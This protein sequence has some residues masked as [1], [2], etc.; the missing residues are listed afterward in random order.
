M[1]GNIS[2]QQENAYIARYLSELPEIQKGDEYV[3]KRGESLWNIA[4]KELAQKGKAP[5]NSEI[6]EYILKIAKLNNLLTQEKMNNI[7]VGENIFL[8][9]SDINK[10]PVT[11]FEIATSYQENPI[12]GQFAKA[13]DPVTSPTQVAQAPIHVVESKPEEAVVSDAIPEFFKFDFA[14]Y[15]DSPVGVKVVKVD[16]EQPQKAEQAKTEI[17][18]AKI[19][20]PEIM[21][22]PA[23]AAEQSSTRYV[24][25]LMKK[26]TFSKSDDEFIAYLNNKKESGNTFMEYEASSLNKKYDKKIDKAEN[27][28]AILKQYKLTDEISE[29]IKKNENDVV[30]NKDYKKINTEKTQE[31]AELAFDLLTSLIEGKEAGYTYNL[32]SDKKA[33]SISK[34]GNF[35]SISKDGDI[36]QWQKAGVSKYDMENLGKLT[37]KQ[38]LDA[39]RKMLDFK[40]A[41]KKNKDTRLAKLLMGEESLEV[42]P[43]KE[44]VAQIAQ[45]KPKNSSEQKV[46]SLLDLASDTSLTIVE[47]DFNADYLG[48]YHLK[49][50]D[51]PVASINY[52]ENKKDITKITAY[53]IVNSRSASFN[54]NRNGEVELCR[55]ISDRERDGQ[56]SK[57]ETEKL[58]DWARNLMSNTVAIA[59]K[60]QVE[61]QPKSQ[62]L[63]TQYVNLQTSRKMLE[64]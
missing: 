18:I 12:K 24:A 41:E 55:S 29:V 25:P 22:S 19:E 3:I 5:K 26:E 14:S 30:R 32:S 36:Q 39:L 42:T 46:M 62:P 28:I 49:K 23:Y 60:K 40:A 51:S 16:A 64:N 10:E 15:K 47:A 56:L 35:Y 58:F 1:S 57:E 8:P 4:K 13:A 6:S 9:K 33:F 27:N 50:G 48:L 54:L 17:P 11:R 38:E 63:P 45:V 7:R 52:D 59:P 20:M 53:G 2:I 61:Q 31:A 37:N 34:D 43:S 44:P 21:N